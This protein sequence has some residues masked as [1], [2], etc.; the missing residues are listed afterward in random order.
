MKNGKSPGNDGL[1][2]EFCLLFNELCDSLIMVLNTSSEVGQLSTSQCQAIIIL[3]DK[4]DK[5]LI[6]KLEA[7]FT[8]KC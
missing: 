5:R 4:K 7:C 6:K 3:I 8:D 1:S 2:E